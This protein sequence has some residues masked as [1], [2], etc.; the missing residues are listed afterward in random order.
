MTENG[1]AS[2]LVLDASYTLEMIKE[3]GMEKSVT[4]RDLD[5]FFR[6]VWSVHP[7]ASLLTSESWSPRFGKPVWHDMGPRHTFIEGKVG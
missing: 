1:K 2:L 4:C 3:R 7:F 6:D 5:G